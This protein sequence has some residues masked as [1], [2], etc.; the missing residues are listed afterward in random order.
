MNAKT[1]KKLRKI[2]GYHPNQPTVYVPH[3]QYSDIQ[4]VNVP[5]GKMVDPKTPHGKY[6][7]L[8]R[9]RSN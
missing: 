9:S 7:D 2:S 6:L 3:I 5:T 1:L 8:K 4:H